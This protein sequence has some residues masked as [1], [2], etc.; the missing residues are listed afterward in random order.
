MRKL[1]RQFWRKTDWGRQIHDPLT[2]RKRSRRDTVFVLAL[3]VGP[4]GNVHLHLLVYGE[5]LPQAM[6]QSLWSA[7]VGDLAIV[8]VRS[9]RGSEG[10]RGAIAYVLKYVL[11][12][13]SGRLPRPEHAAAVEYAL[14]NVRRV[15]IGGAL[16]TVT[17]ADS[18]SPAAE[19]PR[20]QEVMGVRGG[21]CEAC[22][23]IG[24]WSWKGRMP[25][26]EVL[27][28]GGFGLEFK[29]QLHV[30][31]HSTN[32]EALVAV[33][34]EAELTEADPDEEERRALR[35]GA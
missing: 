27:E 17:T 2:G 15:E 13:E 23:S 8:D 25:P 19:E 7:V 10:L 5:F 6:L 28:V 31:A 22:G 16:R 26:S 18:T 30:L 32:G 24:Q 33:S 29:D 1:F 35:E 34:L 4:G 21:S 12:G 11:K 3:E 9:V 14:R 20:L